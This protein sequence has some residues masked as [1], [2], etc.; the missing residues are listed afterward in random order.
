MARTDKED[1]LTAKLSN[2]KPIKSFC[3]F[4]ICPHCGTKKYFETSRS[5]II[6]RCIKV[7]D[8]KDL[9]CGEEYY[10]DLTNIKNK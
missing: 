9:G 1:I 3:G 8:C 4:S 7:R 5:L 10:I 2:V 6:Q